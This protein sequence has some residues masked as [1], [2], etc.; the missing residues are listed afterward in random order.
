MQHL[1]FTNSFYWD[2][3]DQTR[4][5]TKRVL[6]AMGGAYPGMVHAGCYATTLH[7]LKAVAALGVA[8]AKQS[9]AAVVAQ[10]KKMPTQDDAF[11]AGSIRSDGRAVLPAYLLQVKT[12]AESRGDWDYCKLISTMAP[13]DTVKPLAQSACPLART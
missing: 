10:M 4:A 8:R 6:P 7:Y 9:G 13:A 12:P 3:N 11:G 2:T 1:L 5:F